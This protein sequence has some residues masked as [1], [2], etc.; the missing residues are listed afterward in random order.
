[1][2]CLT[3]LPALVVSVSVAFAGS[4]C[5]RLEADRVQVCLD[6]NGDGERIHNYNDLLVIWRERAT[7]D[8][9]GQDSRYTR[10]V[11]T[12][13][14]RGINVLVDNDGFCGMELLFDARTGEFIALETWSDYIDMW[15]HGKHY[16]PRKVDRSDCVVTEVICG[17]RVSVGDS[18]Q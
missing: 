18:V 2:K 14:E 5:C 3:V 13:S 10:Y 12:C 16:W 6:S 4:G 11:A 7:T 15:C 9:I 8:Q 1:M 17:D